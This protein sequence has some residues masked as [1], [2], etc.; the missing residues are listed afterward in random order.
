MRRDCFSITSRLSVLPRTESLGKWNWYGSQSMVP[1]SALRPSMWNDGAKAVRFVAVPGTDPILD[2]E[3]RKALG[4]TIDWL[5]YQFHFPKDSVLGKTLSLDVMEKQSRR[6]ETQILHYDG[7]YWQAYTYAWRDDGSDA[8]LV[9]LDGSEKQISVDDARIP[10]GKREQNWNFASRTQCLTCHTPWAETTLAFNVAQLNKGNQ[11]GELCDLG[12]LKRVKGDGKADTA[13]EEKNTAKLPKL[14]DPLDK[15]AKL[16]ARARS[17]LHT[18]CSH[19]HRNGGGGSVTFELTTGADLKRGLL[20]ARPT[21]GDFGLKDARIIAPGA[22]ER[23]ALYFRMAK[24]GKDRMP[25]IGAEWVDPEGVELMN[26]WIRGLGKP[27]PVTE[28]IAAED[29]AK[30]LATP[31]GA[32]Q[33]ALDAGCVCN[34]SSAILAAAQKLP[35]GHIRDLFEGYFPP[36]KGER[37]LG[38]NPRP[39]AILSPVGDAKR[40]EALFLAERSQCLACHKHAGKGNE[41]GPDL[42]KLTGPRTKEDWLESMLEPSRRVD[43]AFQA[44]TLKSLDGTATTGVLVKKDAKEITLKDALA[45]LITVKVEDVESFTPSRESLMPRGLLADFTAQQ[46]ADILAFLQSNGAPK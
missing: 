35:P 6:I 24:F 22:P 42:A 12:L 28:G 9:A 16:D 8:D 23:S 19:C 31:A 43:A 34:E 25:H 27:D 3:G 45:K 13:Y 20:D 10:G 17:Y 40:G 44:Y 46:A 29:Y 41:I 5:P 37:M 4:G 33:L 15:D 38:Q 1:P 18:N 14:T 26:Q 7:S 30:R 21:R 2:I 32:I 39:K 36:E 11:L